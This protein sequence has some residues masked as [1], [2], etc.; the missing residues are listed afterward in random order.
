MRLKSPA[1]NL[2]DTHDVG[3]GIY[4]AGLLER[5]GIAEAIKTKVTRPDSDIVFELVA[6]GEVELGMV[7]INKIL[8]TPGVDLVGPLPPD[9]LGIFDV[10]DRLAV[11]GDQVVRSQEDAQFAQLHL[12]TGLHLGLVKDDEIIARI[13]FNLG[14]LVLVSAIFDG[15][16]VKAE[17]ARQVVEITAGRVRDVDPDDVGRV[18]AMIGNEIGIADVGECSCRSV[19]YESVDH[20]VVG[21]RRLSG[22]WLVSL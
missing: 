6:N 17:F 12:A 7:V 10:A 21:G 22:R 4:V 18:G 5:L 2:G 13:F 15:E 20:C 3:S 19:E 1:G 9:P 16:W 14:A 11:D 8:T